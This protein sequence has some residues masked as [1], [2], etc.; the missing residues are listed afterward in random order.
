MRGRSGS[1][2]LVS[3]MLGLAAGAISSVAEPM[4]GIAMHGE[5][6]L[7]PDYDHFPYANPDAPRDGSV[8]H[9]WRARH[10]RQPQS[11]SAEEHPDI[12]ARR[13]D[14]EYGNLVYESLMQ[15]SRD[16][17]FT[18]YGLIAETIETDP[19]RTWA[20]FT[21]NPLAKWSD[22]VPITPED[23]IFTYEILTEKGRPPYNRAWNAS[24]RSR[25][26][27]RTR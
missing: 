17:P 3:A 20:E 19:D 18:M 15:R 24:T 4:H 14:P 10:I 22:G 21:I 11:V 8:D 13:V 9:L 7:P 1:I 25:K 2:L 12:R 23:V 6:A 16:E 26:P 5:P 27:A